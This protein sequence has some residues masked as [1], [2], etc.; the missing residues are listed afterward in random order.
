MTSASPIKGWAP[1]I[2]LLAAVSAL[3]LRFFA[4]QSPATADVQL[5]TVSSGSFDISVRTVGVLDAARTHM[6]SST[7]RGDKGKI[8]A[9]VEDGTSVARDDL[10]I[11]LDPTPFETEVQRLGGE[12]RSLEAAADSARQLLEWEKNQMLR[13]NRTA[14][15]NLTVAKL[16][17][18]RLVDGDG[19]LQLAQFKNEL[20]QKREAFSRQQAYIDDLERL[21]AEG[22]ANPAEF[23][24]A[25]KKIVE[26]KEQLTTARRRYESYEKHVLPTQIE[27]ARAKAEKAASEIEEVRRGTEFKVARAVAALAEVDG[28]L[29][30]A[31]NALR[32][33]LDDL[34]KTTIRAPFQGIAILYEAFRD[35]QKRKPRVGDRVWQN[36]P[37]LYLPD[38]STMIVKTRVREVDLYK[39]AVGQPCSVQVDAYPETRY[40]GSVTAIGMLATQA[41]ENGIGD[42]YFEMTVTLEGEDRRLRPGM[43]ARVTVEA[44]MADDTLFVPIHA[45]FNDGI[46]SYCYRLMSP[47]SFL[48]RK[49]VTGRQ[50]EDLVEIVSGLTEGD[51][52][53]LL[54]PP[55]AQV[56]LPPSAS[57]VR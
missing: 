27:A 51:K 36:Q 4:G 15:F 56:V 45:V 47:G 20:D 2:I 54:Q 1:V 39:V 22:Y 18:R 48:R 13:E 19:P 43:T 50:N 28:K 30:S 53:S 31:R 38:I 5:S 35:G 57:E 49:V 3:L 42:K 24:L 25:K 52:I 37:L 29:Q 34:K 32:Q 46:E 55:A 10:L 14:A 44:G 26:L 8:L 33:A 17:L 6:V 21:R 11:H 9:L 41:F 12:V 7:L 23:D 40:A 16:E